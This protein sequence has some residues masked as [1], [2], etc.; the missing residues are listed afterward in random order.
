MADY[1]LILTGYYQANRDAIRSY[2]ARRIPRAYMADDLMQD[3]FIRLWKVRN[4]ICEKTIK[5]LVYT[6]ANNLVTDHLRKYICRRTYHSYAMY[7]GDGSSNVTAERVV[8][9]DLAA[10][11]LRIVSAMPPVRRK[12]YM[13]SRYEDMGI[14][15][16]A[17]EMNISMRTVEAHLYMGRKTVRQR[18]SAC[19]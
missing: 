4:T 3:V 2:I 6:V 14:G 17:Q 16:I 1:E 10:T 12:V 9:D 13:L 7:E 19:V 5:S 18:F 8:A 11:E 15:D